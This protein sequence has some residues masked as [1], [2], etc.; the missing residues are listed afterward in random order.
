MPTIT[1]TRSITKS[2]RQIL[3][4]T[5]EGKTQLPDFQRSWVWND[6]QICSLLA[7][8][9]LSYPIGAVMML[10]TGNPAV[11]FKHLVCLKVFHLVQ[12]QH[13]NL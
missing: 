8:I 2:I 1:S 9:S 13:R 11:K 6:E 12:C 10:E 3:E 5:K 4:N 7:S